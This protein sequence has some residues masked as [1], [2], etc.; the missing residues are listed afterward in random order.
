MVSLS[1]D[2]YSHD[3][4]CI[5]RRPIIIP[6]AP[7]ASGPVSTD[8]DAHVGAVEISN[9]FDLMSSPPLDRKIQRCSCHCAA[10]Q[11][12]RND[13]RDASSIA[14]A[15]AMLRRLRDRCV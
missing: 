1:V 14:R 3:G 5:H 2:H 6:G 11:C 10:S 7:N 8:F 15:Q 4:H 12:E 13:S 9:S